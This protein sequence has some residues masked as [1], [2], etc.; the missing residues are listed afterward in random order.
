MRCA[1]NATGV[2]GLKAVWK[3]KGES[4]LVERLHVARARLRGVAFLWERTGIASD[5]GHGKEGGH[6][7][8][9]ERSAHVLNVRSERAGDYGE[10]RIVMKVAKRRDSP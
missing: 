2:V 8:Q 3:G 7:N 9:G 4:E 6:S 10:C 1:E 5:Q